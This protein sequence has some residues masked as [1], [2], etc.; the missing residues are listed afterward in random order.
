MLQKMEWVMNE[1]LNRSPWSERIS[2]E[3][4]MRRLPGMMIDFGAE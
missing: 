3:E 1:S 4:A 2:E